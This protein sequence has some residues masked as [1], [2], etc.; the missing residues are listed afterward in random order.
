MTISTGL[1]QAK[2]NKT[3]DAQQN[4]FELKELMELSTVELKRWGYE[5]SPQGILY[6]VVDEE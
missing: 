1:H 3:R 6:K 5:I 4:D 2:L